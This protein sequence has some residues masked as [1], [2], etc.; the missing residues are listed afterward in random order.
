VLIR[1]GERHQL[2]VVHEDRV[3]DRIA[4]VRDAVAALTATAF[5]AT[6]PALSPKLASGLAT[7]V[8]EQRARELVRPAT[9]APSPA[10]VDT[11]RA[12]QDVLLRTQR[13]ER[14]Q[15]SARVERCRALVMSARGIGAEIAMSRLL[16]DGFDLDA[17]DS[18]LT[19]GTTASSSGEDLPWVLAVLG[20]GTQGAFIAESMHQ[21]PLQSSTH[22]AVPAAMQG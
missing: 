12:L 6:E 1:Q 22:R 13:A 19:S 7:W 4:D 2:L 21:G 20:S 16:R 8:D 18:L 10:H 9:D 11:L 17:L 15:L 3:S 5:G 14:S